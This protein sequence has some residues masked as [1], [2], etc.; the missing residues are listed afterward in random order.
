MKEPTLEA[1]IEEL[2]FKGNL[3]VE[4]LG[5]L[6]LLCYTEDATAWRENRLD[7]YDEETFSRAMA[8]NLKGRDPM[9]I[10]KVQAQLAEYSLLIEN[11]KEAVAKATT[12]AH[13]AQ[14]AYYAYIF[15][16]SDELR[17]Q[18]AVTL[19]LATPVILTPEEYQAIKETAGGEDPE[20]LA[21]AYAATVEDEKAR[22]FYLTRA[23]LAGFAVKQGRP[24]PAFTE[25]LKALQT[26][27]DPLKDPGSAITQ[28]DL[29]T[30][31]A[32]YY[33]SL[34]YI[35]YFERILNLFSRAYKVP[36]MEKLI[37]VGRVSDFFHG[38]NQLDMMIDNLKLLA[39]VNGTAS[40]DFTLPHF[41]LEKARLT[42]SDRKETLK[43]FKTGN[44]ATDKTFIEY[45]E[46]KAHQRKDEELKN[47]QRQNTH[48]ER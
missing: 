17:H 47:I 11:L 42:N 41:N 36:H 46:K 10:L 22:E 9:E 7:T 13:T 3:T 48:G 43:L 6:W 38:K 26:F 8:A 37:D 15:Q 34:T 23:A 18:T 2:L 40:Q 5:R 28:E 39:R 24:D 25:H 20:K 12:Y 27:T 1:L 33:Y 21:A 30:Y 29:N 14:S 45:L 4:E 19:Q 35:Y 16:I 44:P 32:A 31:V